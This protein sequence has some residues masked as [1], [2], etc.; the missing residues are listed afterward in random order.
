VWVELSTCAKRLRK[1]N[2]ISLPLYLVGALPGSHAGRK[3]ESASQRTGAIIELI[4]FV[5]NLKSIL[6]AS[7]LVRW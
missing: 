2:E 5:M 4:D 3:V 1:P 7:S 6:V